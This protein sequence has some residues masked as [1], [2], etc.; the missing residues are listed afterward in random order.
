MERNWEAS[1]INSK[2]GYGRCVRVRDGR[3]LTVELKSV[4]HRFLDISLRMPRCFLFLEDE[5]RKAVGRRL[6]RGH[7]DVFCTYRNQREDAR[8]VQVD[9]GLI[10]AYLRATDGLAGLTDDRSVMGVL[11]LP[12]VV[13]VVEAEEDREALRA[14]LLE[15]LEG[16]LD[17]AAAMRAVEGEALQRDLNAR[18]DA[19]EKIA[20]AIAARAPQTLI[21][22]R[23]RLRANVEELLGGQ[24]DESRL[25]QETAIM[26]D[27]LAIDEELVRLESHI[28]QLR[29]LTGDPAP[30]GRRLDFL[31]Q[32]FNREVNTIASKSQDIEITR[33]AMEGKAEIE[34]LR[35]QVQNVE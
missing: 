4:N 2:T 34:K 24:M 5:A 22:Y 27:R 15:T 3:S 17:E 25:V 12:E 9:E 29:A 23:E 30:A 7:V 1:S 13:Q 31:A 14:L 10:R 32:E 21:A 6:A 8:A 28:A 18:A 35:E 26:A 33:L 16:A 11:S 20:R 19:L